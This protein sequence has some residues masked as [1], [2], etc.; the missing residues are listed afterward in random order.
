MAAGYLENV[1]CHDRFMETAQNIIAATY[2]HRGKFD[3]IACTGTSGVAIGPYIAAILKKP[4]MVVRK[5]N[6][7]NHS[8]EFVETEIEHGKKVIWIFLDDLISTGTTLSRVKKKINARHRRSKHYGTILYRD[9]HE[10]KL[11]MERS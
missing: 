6:E 2:G 9:A 7:H 10:E 4:V 1:L 3:A 11:K 8:D 5:D